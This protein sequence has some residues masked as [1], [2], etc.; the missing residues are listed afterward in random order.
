LYT[1]SFG[2]LYNQQLDH[3]IPQAFA[4]DFPVYTKSQWKSYAKKL[5]PIYTSVR[6]LMF[7]EA[8]ILIDFGPYIPL[9]SF[10]SV[11]KQV[12]SQYK[13]R[14]LIDVGANGF[15]ASPK[16]L[17]DSYSIYLPFTDAIMIEPEPHFSASVPKAYSTRYNISYLP[18]YAE[19]NTGIIDNACKDCDNRNI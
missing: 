1:D 13:K 11:R 15:F 3:F 10:S 5:E 18:I 6:N 7:H 17:L 19:V 12:R 4:P 8:A 14:V 9:V 2:K 16:Y